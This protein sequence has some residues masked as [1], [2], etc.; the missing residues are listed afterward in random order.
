M[1]GVKGSGTSFPTA[2]AASVGKGIALHTAAPLGF[3]LFVRA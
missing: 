3:E 1:E 2:W